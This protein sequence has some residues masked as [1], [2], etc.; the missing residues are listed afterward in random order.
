M[1][2]GKT[3]AIRKREI[4]RFRYKVVQQRERQKT[5]YS[6][7]SPKGTTLFEVVKFQQGEVA[8]MNRRECWYCNRVVI[9]VVDGR[10]VLDCYTNHPEGTDVQRME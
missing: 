6:V 8:A 5:F 3:V 10:I 2:R 4:K 9:K 1:Q 7:I